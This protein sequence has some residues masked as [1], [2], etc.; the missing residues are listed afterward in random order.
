V[1]RLRAVINAVTEAEADL[2]P[3]QKRHLAE[4]GEWL[5]G[6]ADPALRPEPP[7]SLLEAEQR[8]SR[9]AKDAAAAWLAIGECET[10]ATR[11]CEI[12]TLAISAQ[13]EALHGG[14]VSEPITG[15]ASARLDVSFS[16]RQ[17]LDQSTGRAPQYAQRR[18]CGA[19]IASQTLSNG[20][21]SRR[22]REG[23]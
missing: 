2:E 11:A 22:A 5:S 18:S 20:G 23:W 13:R 1:N 17:R 9:C 3:R 4:I 21:A 10:R 15:V 12:L 6:G 19:I 8:A 14:G 16:W 7:P